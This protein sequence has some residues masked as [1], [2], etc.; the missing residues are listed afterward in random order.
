[1]EDFMN[2]AMPLLVQVASAVIL[3]LIGWAANTA[4]RK[5]GIDIEA[6]YQAD[7]HTALTTAARLALSKQLTGA[8]AMDL[9]LDYA[10]RSVPDA[11]SKLNPPQAV[12]ENLA[13]SKIEAVKADPAFQTGKAIGEAI[14]NATR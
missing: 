2:E 9:I 10:K 13:K 4:R 7:L 5:W 12:I 8:A 14:K 3:G 1:M 11:L 6:K